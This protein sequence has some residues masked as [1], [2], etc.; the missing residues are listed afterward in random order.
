MKHS[1]KLIILCLGI[2][3]VGFS[4]AKTVD[5]VKGHKPI[6]PK[7]I[8]FHIGV[9]KEHSSGDV[10]N[11]IVKGPNNVL[12]FS[13][14]KGLLAKA[15]DNAGANSIS[16]GIH[17]GGSYI[18]N[19]HDYNTS[20]F[21]MYNFIGQTSPSTIVAR[22]SGSPKAAGFKYEVGP[23][24]EI[25]IGK[26]LISPMVTAGYMSTKNQ[27]MQVVQNISMDSVTK[28]FTLYSQAESN[29]KGF[30]ITP[31]LRL[32]YMFGKFGIWVEGNY[33][34]GAQNNTIA[35]VFTP[36]GKANVHGQYSISQINKPNSTILEQKQA[37]KNVGL[38]LGVQFRRPPIIIPKPIV[39]LPY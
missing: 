35:E 18:M 9:G 11:T 6:M 38:T 5:S 12:N 23:Q 31:K 14:Y 19:N 21:S 37:I 15:L 16:V 28:E 39:E 24:V 36:E 32:A 1:L 29:K 30:V 10:G 27:A 3:T 33:S 7:P 4:Q 34:I 25:Q 13:L 17:L 8:I 2:S 20:G 26:I 22:G